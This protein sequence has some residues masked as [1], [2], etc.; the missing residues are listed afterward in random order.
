MKRASTPHTPH[1]SSLERRQLAPVIAFTV[2]AP[3]KSSPPSS[4]E[5]FLPA[6]WAWHFRMLRRLRERLAAECDEHLHAA[7]AASELRPADFED[8]ADSETECDL[9]FAE[10]RAEEDML[11][12][13][14][15]A[16]RRLRLG[17]YGVCEES[18]KR[19]PATRLRAMPW[20]RYTC[21]VAGRLEKSRTS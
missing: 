11:A 4:P 2:G 15:A 18:G 8:R 17:T 10:L 7:T 1:A 19:I 9:L 12:E 13:V 16:L 21:A 6:K 20:A 3:A 5:P 14:E